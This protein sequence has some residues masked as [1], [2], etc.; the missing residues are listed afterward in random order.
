MDKGNLPSGLHVSKSFQL[1]VFIGEDI[2]AEE[3][4]LIDAAIASSVSTNRVESMLRTQSAGAG[5]STLPEYLGIATSTAIYQLFS[6][7]EPRVEG[8]GCR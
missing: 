3:A 6:Y 2:D 7:C 8:I 5:P 4:Q 1:T